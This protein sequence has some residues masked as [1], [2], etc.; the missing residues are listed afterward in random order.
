[1]IAKMEEDIENVK[2]LTEAKIKKLR[3]QDNELYGDED[4]SSSSDNETGSGSS[5]ESEE[6]ERHQKPRVINVKNQKST[7]EEKKKPRLIEKK[8]PKK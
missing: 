3:E 8:E 6:E 2:N 7:R 5:S 1:V 4:V